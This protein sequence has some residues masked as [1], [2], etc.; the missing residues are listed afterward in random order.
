MSKNTP[1]RNILHNEKEIPCKKKYVNKINEMINKRRLLLKRYFPP[2]LSRNLHMGFNVE[3]SHGPLMQHGDGL[4]FQ[5]FVGPLCAV[6]GLS[7]VCQCKQVVGL[8]YFIF[9]SFS[10]SVN[11]HKTTTQH[12]PG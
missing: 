3:R 12:L 1:F 6:S 2:F 4:I 11:V 7:A 8:C 10:V 9:V 5:L